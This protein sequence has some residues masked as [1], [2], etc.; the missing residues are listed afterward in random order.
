[1]SVCQPSDALLTNGRVVKET[2][3]VGE[4]ILT[5]KVKEYEQVRHLKTTNL[6]ISFEFF[7]L[8]ANQ[9]Y[10]QAALGGFYRFSQKLTGQSQGDLKGAEIKKFISPESC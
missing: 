10:G 4:R 3:C 2:A 8:K 6:L 7:L 1:M 9:F 5:V